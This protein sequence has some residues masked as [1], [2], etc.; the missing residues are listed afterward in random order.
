MVYLQK[1]KNVSSKILNRP[2]PPF[3]LYIDQ[4][5]VK[6]KLLAFFGYL[7]HINFLTPMSFTD[8]A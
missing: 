4:A 3:Y 7:Q 5:K 6:I 2:L 1:W 8:F